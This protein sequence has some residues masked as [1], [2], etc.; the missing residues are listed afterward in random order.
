MGTMAYMSPEQ[1]RGE[2][3]DARTDLF[4]FGAVLYEMAT[5]QM[6]FSGNTAAVIHDGILNRTPSPLRGRNPELP[7]ELEHIVNKAL[8]KDRKLRYQHAAEIRTDLL[9]LKR[10]TESQG[11][12][13]IGVATA[14]RDPA[15]TSSVGPKRRGLVIRG[16]V[17]AVFIVAAT[18]G[19]WLFYNRKSHALS[20]TDTI[21]LADFTNTTSDEVFDGALRQGLAVQLEQSPF[22]SLVSDE[23]IRQT[24]RLMG[25][26]A[27]T[28]LTPEIARELCQRTESAAVL[29]GSIANLGNQYILG[30]KA[31]N[32]RSGDTLA[33]EQVTAEGKER[34]LKGLSDATTK[35]RGKLG[36]SLSVVK[37][38]D[39]S[40][41]EATTPSL[42]ALQAYS[43][44]YR[45]E[46]GAET[47]PLFERAISVDPKF[48]MAHAMLG[49]SY[50]NVGEANRAT[51]NLRRAYQLRAHTSEPERLFIESHYHDIAIGDLEKARG[52]YEL[53]AKT[54]PRD[55]VPLMELGG[56]Y[57]E[58]GQY[59]QALQKNREAFRLNPASGL[60]YSH[61]IS[62]YLSLNR[63]AEAR[64]TAQEALAKKPDSPPLRLEL[65]VLG[66]LSEDAAGMAQQ[67]AWAAGKVGVEDVMLAS[68]ANTAS[69]FGQLENARRFSRRAVTA[70]EH[71]NEKETAAGYEAEAAMREALVGNSTEARQRATAALGFSSGRDELYGATLAL[72]VAGDVRTRALADDLEKRFAEDTL[73]QYKYLPT[74]RAQLGL[75]QNEPT[76]AIEGLQAAIPYELGSDTFKPYPIYVRGLAYLA[77]GRGVEAAA[78]FQKILDHRGI[79][80]NAITGALA[81]LGLARAYVL[82]RNSPEAA[83][84][85][86]RF[87]AL[88]KDADPNIPIL[89]QA[90]LEYARLQ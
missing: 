53:W 76:K 75:Q 82:Q 66:F 6:A 16:A 85:Y 18:V 56:V 36:E 49:I 78:E 46:A 88:W 81:H 80:R 38:L 65:Y 47:V 2:E 73:V 70:A 20:A 25:Q 83:K 9:R 61:L 64:S 26:R 84:A 58:L 41:E 45:T 13:A 1:A 29:E 67:V 3:L 74:I 11:T 34:V 89:K 21:V 77:E 19:G 68:E 33:E 59:E 40:I 79:V 8:D 43:L 52:E 50:A 87:L 51:E 7:P 4:S 86:Q 27:D 17:A 30:L 10:D 60:I 37:K 62:N 31:V 39:T 14:A 48:A 42:E 44:G 22:L 72:A 71:A 55:W 15:H 35:L 54:Y 23:R 28:R 90:E 24:L 57:S 32:C 5:G 69:Y 12:T 63:L